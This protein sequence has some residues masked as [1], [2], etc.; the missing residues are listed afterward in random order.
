[1]QITKSQGKTVEGTEASHERRSLV[2]YNRCTRH[3]KKRSLCPAWPWN[4]GTCDAVPLCFGRNRE[5]E[6]PEPPEPLNR[7]ATLNALLLSSFELAPSAL[8]HRHQLQ[9]AF[10]ERHATWS[11]RWSAKSGVIART[12]C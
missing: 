8:P 2:H 11:C 10:H 3:K 4:C 9:E 5:P 12:A 1:M 6:P 7:G